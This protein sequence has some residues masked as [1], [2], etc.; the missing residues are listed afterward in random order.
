[1]SLLIILRFN[2]CL[3]SFIISFFSLLFLYICV[4]KEFHNLRACEGHVSPNS[5]ASFYFQ[6][7][8]DF[9]PFYEYSIDS[10]SHQMLR[11]IQNSRKRIVLR[12]LASSLVQGDGWTS[13][14]RN[15]RAYQPV[16]RNS[17]K[18]NGKLSSL[19]SFSGS[20]KGISTNRTN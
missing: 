6:I 10:I 18:R 15:E 17:G 13:S 5:S 16:L 8:H 2:L 14:V 12:Y 19:L 7:S 3:L 11:G 1:M 20:N 9:F 4:H